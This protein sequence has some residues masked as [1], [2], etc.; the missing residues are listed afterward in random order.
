M[1]APHPPSAHN[2][3]RHKSH[4]NETGAAYHARPLPAKAGVL[5][6]VDQRAHYARLP[7]DKHAGTAP[8]R[9]KAPKDTPVTNSGQREHYTG[10]EL[11]PYSGRPGAMDAFALP[12]RM[13]NS[14]HWRDGR[15]APHTTASALPTS[16]AP[17]P[18]TTPAPT[19]RTRKT[20]GA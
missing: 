12:S 8:T 5:T 17:A 1:T 2:A 18:A 6:S 7:L 14:L 15:S 19:A 9:A 16:T 4:P 11:A 20:K 3:P 10:A 13:G